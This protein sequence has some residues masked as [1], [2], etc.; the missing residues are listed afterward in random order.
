MGFK[1]GIVLATGDNAGAKENSKTYP[2]NAVRVF[3][4]V[5]SDRHSGFTCYCWNHR[6]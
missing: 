4:Q 5:C 6:L 1:L 3:A 2:K